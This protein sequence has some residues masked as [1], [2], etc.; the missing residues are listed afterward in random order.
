R[1]LADEVA[2]GTG[3]EIALQRGDRVRALR[4]APG[5]LVAPR[6]ERLLD[7]GAELGVGDPAEERDGRL[8]VAARDGVE[9]L[10]HR[11]RLA[12]LRG[13]LLRLAAARRLRERRGELRGALRRLRRQHRR[14]R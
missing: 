9:G 3:V 10:L 5:M 12:P 6:L 8:A 14:E 7:V 4:F 1:S 2:A 11:A 13:K